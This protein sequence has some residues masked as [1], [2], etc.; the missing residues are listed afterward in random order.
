MIYSRSYEGGALTPDNWAITPAIDLSGATAPAVSYSVK[1]YFSGSLADT[2]AI[3]AGTSANPSEMTVI[4]EDYQPASAWT[5]ET[6]DLSDYAGESTVYVAFRHYNCTDKY[7]VLVD[8]VIVGESSALP[9]GERKIV[10]AEKSYAAPK[11]NLSK[12]VK[13]GDGVASA[14]VAAE[15]AY[16]E[17]VE[18]TK[19]GQPTNV[20][21][22]STNAIKSGLKKVAFRAPKDETTVENGNVTIALSDD[23]ATTNGLFTVTY[24]PEV[25]TYVDAL[26]E[27]PYV[28]IHNEIVKPADVVNE[29]EE[30]A[31][32]S[33][34]ITVAYA[35]VEEIAAED[36]IASLNFT[37]DET[38]DLDT[39]VTV[40]V[41][42]RN[43]NLAV[44][45]DA[46]DIV[47]KAAPAVHE[48]AYGEPEWT[49]TEDLTSATA[50]FTCE[51]GDVQT[52]EDNEI[53]EEVTKEARPHVAGEK[54]LTA[55]VEFNGETYTDTKTV[56]IEALPCPCENFEDMPEVGTPEHEA[57][58][59]AYT[60]EPYQ[61]T[62]GMDAT[63][64]GTDLIVT[65]AQAMTFLWAAM[66]KPEPKATT[67]MF[68]DVKVSKWYF[69]PITWAVENGITA[70][71]GNN[72]FSPNKTCTHAEMIQFLYATFGKPETN[73]E[74]PYTNLGKKWYKNAAI[75]AY[76]K[77]IE[78]GENGE[79]DANA[80][81]TRATTVLYIYR[82]LTGQGLPELPEE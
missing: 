3:Y 31:K 56:E 79:F 12:A 55:S 80:P 54:T 52:V 7:Q 69:K 29:D 77:G 76:E 58:D 50:T 62:A 30:P 23:V 18:M 63:H 45:E 59:W 47:L 57:I 34:V 75:W 33:G 28:S 73:I 27:L 74:N 11:L 35:S 25:L 26:S 48:H 8:N 82:A 21:S 14:S 24:D 40:K 2:M 38:V 65:R 4:K 68:T 22:G 41:L 66:D 53:D 64:F 32:D 37:Y 60:H 44:E 71:T 67:S 43:D 13:V 46:L 17:T 15:A 1:N 72:K 61:I 9:T 78:R 81:C 70:G 20:A 42:E 49:W 51:C 39:V 36:V 16:T 19:L 10:A 5:V 6:L